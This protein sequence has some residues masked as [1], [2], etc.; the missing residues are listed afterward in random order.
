MKGMRRVVQIKSIE[1][2]SKATKRA[3]NSHLFVQATG[4][5]RQYRVTNRDNGQ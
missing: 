4:I 1:Q 5:D 2:L 3:R